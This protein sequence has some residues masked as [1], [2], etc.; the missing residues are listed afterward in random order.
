MVKSLILPWQREPPIVLSKP[1]GQSAQETKGTN[2][3]PSSRVW[4]YPMGVV[5]SADIV[6][7]VGYL[8]E[9]RG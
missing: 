1:A 3:L 4:D 7:R 8:L 6:R 2:Q 9:D 5:K